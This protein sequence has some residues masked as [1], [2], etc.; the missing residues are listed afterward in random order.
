VDPGLLGLWDG[1]L[2]LGSRYLGPAAGRWRVLDAARLGL[3]LRRLC[4]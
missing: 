3:E 4:L 1:W 2:L